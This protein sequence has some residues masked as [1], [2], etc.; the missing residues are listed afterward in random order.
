MQLISASIMSA[1]E[2][3]HEE[4]SRSARYDQNTELCVAVE[5]T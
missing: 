1:N 3:A 2:N 5:S 4:L